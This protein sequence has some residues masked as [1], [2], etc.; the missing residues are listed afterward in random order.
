MK[1]FIAIAGVVSGVFAVLFFI[2]IYDKYGVGKSLL[3]CLAGVAVIC[4][5]AYLKAR[6]FG[7]VR[8]IGRKDERD[9][10]P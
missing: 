10:K 2:S 4:A 5:L 1:V 6:L 8:P 9:P 7:W 3:L